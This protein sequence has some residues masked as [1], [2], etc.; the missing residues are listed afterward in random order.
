MFGKCFVGGVFEG[1][2]VV[3]FDWWFEEELW[4]CFSYVCMVFDCKCR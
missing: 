4:K 1:V 3:W 2:F